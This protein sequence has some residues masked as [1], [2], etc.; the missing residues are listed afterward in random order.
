MFLR[1]VLFETKVGERFLGWFE[2]VTGLALVD[3][4]WLAEQR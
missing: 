2:R 1:R 4:A 3:A